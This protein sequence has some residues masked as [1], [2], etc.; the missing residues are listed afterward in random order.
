[1]GARPENTPFLLTPWELSNSSWLLTRWT[2]PSPHTARPGLKKS[3]RKSLA[4]SRRSD[5]TQLLFHSSPSLAGTET[6]CCRPRLLRRLSR[7][8]EMLSRGNLHMGIKSRIFIGLHYISG[9]RNCGDS[10]ISGDFPK[11]AYISIAK[12]FVGYLKQAH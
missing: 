1:M 2:P 11:F 7:R 12:S 8:N 5:T 6:T 9:L 3:R 4:S 10:R